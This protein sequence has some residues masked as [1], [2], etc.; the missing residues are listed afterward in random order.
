MSDTVSRPSGDLVL[1]LTS[2]AVLIPF[3][4]WVVWQGGVALALASAGFALAMG[5]EWV[6]MSASPLMKKVLPLAMLPVLIAAVLGPFFGVVS[7]IV[8]AVLSGGLHPLQEERVPSAAGL[9]YIAGMPLALFLLREGAWDGAA[10]ALILM[11]MVWGSDSAAY[12]T[13]KT[14]GGPKLTPDSPSKTWSGAG[15]AVV[16][17]A[18][19]G[20]LAARI[21]G[22]DLLVWL[23]VSVLISVF[24]Q[25]GD[26]VES[27]MK[28][29]YGVKDAS[30]LIPGHGG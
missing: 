7:L 15:G 13:G 11:G 4:L 24:A 30:S 26:L 12:F 14:L 29:R 10:A 22:G 17:T 21:T 3:A 25:M 8:C 18:L 28:R 6:R 1:R 5:Y 2:A 19:C 16:F 20:I 27:R 23:C 9:A